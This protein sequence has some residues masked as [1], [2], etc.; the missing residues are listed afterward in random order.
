MDSP[1]S[2]SN[3]RRL[4]ALEYALD[5]EDYGRGKRAAIAAHYSPRSAESMASKLLRDPLVI[6]EIKK[7]QAE[8]AKRL[9]EAKERAIV[10]YEITVESVIQE[11]AKLAFLD[12]RKFFHADGRPKAITELDDNTA[13][14]LAGMDIAESEKDGVVK[15]YKLTDK[16]GALELLGRHLKMWVDRVEQTTADEHAASLTD[17]ELAR[18]L[19][20][21]HEPRPDGAVPARGS[22]ATDSK[23]EGVVR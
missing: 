11:V 7:C 4:F 6:A 10:K 8:V 2:L 9:E 21:N 17:E 22:V 16:K 1:K 12:P 18:K 23:T 14:A 15:K 3:Q 19:T 20:G 5:P 13:A